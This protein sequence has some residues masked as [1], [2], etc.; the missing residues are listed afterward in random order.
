MMSD[1]VALADAQITIE[2]SERPYQEFL[3]ARSHYEQFSE[4][5]IIVDGVAGVKERGQS[6]SSEVNEGKKFVRVILPLKEGT[7]DIFAD[8]KY[9]KE[10]NTLVASFKFSRE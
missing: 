10:F 3:E 1:D 7:I 5:T 6:Q 8:K 2:V 4:E 9:E